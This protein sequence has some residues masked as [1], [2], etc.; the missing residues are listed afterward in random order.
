MDIANPNVLDHHTEIVPIDHVPP[1]MDGVP[2]NELHLT[3]SKTDARIKTTDFIT[4]FDNG[5]VQ[6]NLLF[7][8]IFTC[9]ID[10]EHF[11]S[12]DWG[13]SKNVV[14]MGDVYWF[15]KSID[16]MSVFCH[17]LRGSK[18]IDYFCFTK[19]TRSKQD[20]RLQLALLMSCLCEGVMV[21]IEDHF[22]DAEMNLII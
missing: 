3:Y 7:T 16:L 11:A 19:K 6:P 12:G 21:S 22:S 1:R 5:N 15:S 18:L 9:P 17:Q 8:A 13:E 14:R 2:L 10:G 20:L 4:V